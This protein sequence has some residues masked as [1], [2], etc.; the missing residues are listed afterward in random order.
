MQ[1]ILSIRPE[2]VER[3]FSGVKKFEYRKVIFIRNDI[4]TVVVYATKPFGKVVGEFEIGGIIVN[5]PKELW[6]QTKD[7]SGISKPYFNEYFKG[8]D[9]GFAIKIKNFKKY[10]QPLDLSVYDKNIKAVPQSFC[11]TEV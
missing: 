9:Q 10:D 7:Y 3:I 5:N 8:K 4:S 2:F 11:Y 1:V 6:K